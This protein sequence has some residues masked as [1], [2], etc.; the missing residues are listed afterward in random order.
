MSRST[1]L[2]QTPTQR[3]GEERIQEILDA[4]EDLVLEIGADSVTTN[5]IARRTGVNVGTVYHFFSDKFQ[6]FHAVVARAL[7]DLEEKV[8]EVASRPAASDAEWIERIIDVHAKV[9]L[10]RVASI[11]LWTSVRGRPEMRSLEQE[12]DARILPEYVRGLKEHCPHIPASRRRAVARVVNDVLSA[13]LDDAVAARTR[14]ERDATL[15][16]MG[17]LLRTYVCG[18]QE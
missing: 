7:L 16:E 3:R 4:T 6:I 12:Y 11:R 2:R 10:D 17:I 14:G 9:W 13:L 1:K 8:R 18:S 15:R 5:H